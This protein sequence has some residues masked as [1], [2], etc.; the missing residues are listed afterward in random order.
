M[1]LVALA[2]DQHDHLEFPASTRFSEDQAEGAESSGPAPFTGSAP[3]TGPTSVSGPASGS[4]PASSMAVSGS[5]A[6]R[7]IATSVCPAARFTSRTPIVWRD[8]CLTSA[9]V[10]LI[11]PP[12][13]VI[14]YTSSSG[15]TI[16]APINSPRASTI[17]A[18]TTPRPPRPLTGYWSAGV[19]LA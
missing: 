5:S 18:V 3:F 2:H 6:L 14:A 10:V 15:P 7:A 13:D 11:T 1:L 19:R 4:G 12:A 9:A 17:R 8:D 16:S